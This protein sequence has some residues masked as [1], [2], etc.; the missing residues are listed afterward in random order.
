M[1]F[2]HSAENLESY[3]IEQIKDYAIFAMDTKGII[4]TWNKGCERIK[5]YTPEEAIGQ[6][7]GMLYP[8]EYQQAVPTRN[9]EQLYK[10][11]LSRQKTGANAKMV[12][13]SGLQLP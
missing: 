13:F 8:D 11:A 1:N 4:N 2:T 3:F 10:M 7:Y 12:L 5:G 9:W 6:F